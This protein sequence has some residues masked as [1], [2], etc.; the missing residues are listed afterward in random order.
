MP[1]IPS[2]KL[3]GDA[4]FISNTT[5]LGE[6]SFFTL[7]KYYRTIIDSKKLQDYRTRYINYIIHSNGKKYKLFQSE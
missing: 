7:S 6:E 5:R 4:F 1:R 2:D 3:Q